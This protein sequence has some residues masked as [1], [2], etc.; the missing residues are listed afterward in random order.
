[1]NIFDILQQKD[2]DSNCLKK[3]S[4]VELEND[5]PILHLEQHLAKLQ[6]EALRK[7]ELY[8]QLDSKIAIYEKI[9]EILKIAQVEEWKLRYSKLEEETNDLRK[10]PTIEDYNSKNTLIQQ[11]AI[12]LKKAKE[13]TVPKEKFNQLELEKDHL[14]ESLQ[15]MTSDTERLEAIVVEY[16]KQI[17]KLQQQVGQL[18]EKLATYNTIE[19]NY[20]A[21]QIAHEDLQ[22]KFDQRLQQIEQLNLKLQQL[23]EQIEQM[24]YSPSESKSQQQALII[25]DFHVE[26]VESL[27]KVLPLLSEENL[28]SEAA[29]EEVK[30]TLGQSPVIELALEEEKMEGITFDEFSGEVSD[31]KELLV[32]QEIDEAQMVQAMSEILSKTVPT[33]DG[34]VVT[35]FP[36]YDWSSFLPRNSESEHNYLRKVIGKI[37]ASMREIPG[38]EFNSTYEIDYSTAYVEGIIRKQAYEHNNKL[39]YIKERPYIGRVDYVT[40]VGAETI[41]IGEQG[42][43]DYVIS[44]KAE[45]ASLYYLRAVGHPIAHQTLGEV[46]VD[47]IRQIDIESGRIKK[48]HPPITSTSQYFKDEGLVSALEN[49]RGTDMQSIVATLQREQY[50]MIRLPMNQPII[51]QGSAGSGKSA[52]ALHRLSYLLYK[53]QNLTP[54]SVAILGPNKAFLKHI[55]NVLPTL[56]DFGIKQTTFSELACDILMI[57][58]SKLIRHQTTELE[59]IKLKGSLDFR[60]ILQQTTMSIINDLRIWAKA[61][62]LKSISIPIVPIL[63]EMEKYPQLTLK[64]RENL[65]FNFFIKSMQKEIHNKNEEQQQLKQWVKDKAEAIVKQE[66][67]NLSLSHNEF[68]TT[69]IAQLGNQWDKHLDSYQTHRSNAKKK[70]ADISRQQF[71]TAIQQAVQLKMKDHAVVLQ[72]LIPQSIDESIITEAWKPHVQREVQKAKEAIILKHIREQQFEVFSVAVVTDTSIVQQHLKEVQELVLQQLAI[73]QQSFYNKLKEILQ[74]ALLSE[75]LM[76]MEQAYNKQITEALIIRYKL[77]YS[78]SN[79]YQGYKFIEYHVSSNESDILK[80]Y[81]IKHLELDYLDCFDEAIRVAK[82]K[83][84][85]PNDYQ[86]FDIFYEDLPALLHISR[87]IKGVPKEHMLSYL[88]VDEAQDYMPYEIVEMHALTKKNGLMLIG[89]LGQN[90]NRASSLQDWHTLDQVIGEPAY[91]ELKATYRSTAQIVEVSNEIIKPFATGKYKLSSETFRDGEEVEWVEVTSKTE[92][93]RLIEILEDAIITNNYESVAVIV[94]DESLLDHFNYM[95]DPYFSVAIQTESDLPRNVKVIITTPTAV[96]GLEFEAVVIARFNDYS[97][98]DFDRKLAYVATS[99]ALHHL[100]ITY[101]QG[102]SSIIS[103][104]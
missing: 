76:M 54:D 17:N 31:E 84:L 59:I 61:Y 7:E 92:E 82:I 9:E 30:L 87:L 53:Y 21:L 49:K 19:S 56:G 40:V 66:V 57:S 71:I 89:D 77:D 24:E 68:I 69:E 32:E 100:Y 35:T 3:Q 8:K 97:F 5:P 99:R 73:E 6:E 18:E 12:Q 98:T 23:Q 72:Q 60:T 51:I 36:N 10:R 1:M 28:P 64:E 102:K 14:K 27:S 95:I 103:F 52:I 74:Q 11:L 47:Y 75:I 83:G 4:S 65:Y 70:Q 13:A 46:I 79:K 93:Q 58:P 81:V 88:I 80:N 29:K 45:A 2:K 39:K 94:K 37:D 50:E 34:G 104:N 25:D 62:T 22:M 86:S 101:E 55:Q 48:L 85:L 63:K 16:E 91:Y 90:L 67:N 20:N 41:Y 26:D 78:F 15:I 44:W 33:I 43:D 96:K 38:I 42:I